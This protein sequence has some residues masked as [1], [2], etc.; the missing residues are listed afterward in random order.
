MCSYCYPG[1]I[2]LDM[3]PSFLKGLLNKSRGLTINSIQP[4]YNRLL[5]LPFLL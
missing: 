3:E 5:F 2:L 1:D 4:I